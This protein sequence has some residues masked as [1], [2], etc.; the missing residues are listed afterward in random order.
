MLRLHTPPP[1]LL[2]NFCRS[3][4]AIFAGLRVKTTE[5]EDLEIWSTLKAAVPRSRI[6][7]A[8]LTLTQRTNTT[9]GAQSFCYS[10]SSPLDAL[11]VL[12]MK[13]SLWTITPIGIAF[14]QL[15]PRTEGGFSSIGLKCSLLYTN[16]EATADG[17]TPHLAKIFL[18]EF[19]NLASHIK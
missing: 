19:S 13:L 17:G 6:S 12:E 8:G 16:A 7:I 14:P 18:I 10:C 2:L 1:Q 4:S 3:T 5:N 9:V 15:I 11:R